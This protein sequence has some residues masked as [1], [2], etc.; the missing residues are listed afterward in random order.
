MSAS[1]QRDSKGTEHAAA[2][3]PDAGPQRGGMIATLNSVS[4]ALKLLP[5]REEAKANWT[6][7]EW[8]RQRDGWL[9]HHQPAGVSRETAAPHQHVARHAGAAHHETRASPVRAPS[10][11]FWTSSR[12]YMRCRSYTQRSPRAGRPET[13]LCSASKGAA[14]FEELYGRKAEAML[15]QPATKVFLRTDEANS[16]KWISQTSA[17]WKSSD[18]VKA[19][20]KAIS[21]GTGGIP[22]TTS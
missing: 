5:R 13:Q 15:S 12:A 22:V 2:I 10:G 9:F 3:Y 16:S 14:N 8:A 18:C 21:P 17:K 20:W 4:N 1:W 11:S 19:A 6:A 7:V